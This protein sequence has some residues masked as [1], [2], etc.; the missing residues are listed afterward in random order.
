MSDKNIDVK[1]AI[2]SRVRQLR[3]LHQKQYIQQAS[4][5]ISQT[6]RTLDCY[7]DARNIACFLSFDGEIDTQHLIQMLH[8][9]K[10]HCFLPKLRPSKPNRLWFMPYRQNSL[11]INNRYGIPEVDLSVNHAIA[12]SQLDIILMPLVAFDLAG[13]RL[14]M[15]GGFYDA[16]LAHL[17]GKKRSTRPTCIGLAYENQK[18]EQIPVEK[19]DFKLDGILTEKAF[20]SM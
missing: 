4:T 6:F 10:T 11:L 16:T 3:S 18:V 9:D 17:A 2:R 14:G 12:I 13:N 20:Y 19:W 7:K 5:Q 15:G 8:Q 1:Q